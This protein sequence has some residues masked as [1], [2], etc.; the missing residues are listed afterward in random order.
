MHKGL[1]S[2]GPDHSYEQGSGALTLSAAHCPSKGQ[3]CPGSCPSPSP[4]QP[5]QERLPCLHQHQPHPLPARPLHKHPPGNAFGSPGGSGLAI[6]EWSPEA[7][8]SWSSPSPLRPEQHMKH[9]Q[10]FHP[11]RTAPPACEEQ[12]ISYRAAGTGLP[13][14]DDLWLHTTW[15]YR[16]AREGANRGLLMALE[17]TGKGAK[18]KESCVFSHCS[19][20]L[21]WQH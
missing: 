14:S 21:L 19:G 13:Q 5:A 15:L 8:E 11:S 17:M 2:R 20:N 16:T 6:R 1:Q 3:R 10:T 12:S 7:Q 4:A 18:W 9:A